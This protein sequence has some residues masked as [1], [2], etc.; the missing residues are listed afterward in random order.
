LLGGWQLS[1]I[2]TARQGNGW[3]SVAANCTL[4]SAGSCYADLN[5]NFTGPIRINGSPSD[6]NLRATNAPSFLAT[7]VF[8]NP[9]AYA[10]GN[11]PRSYV[12]KLHNVNSF[13]QNASLKREFRLRERMKLAL[14]IDASN[15][16]NMVIFG[17]P[18]NAFNSTAYG[19]VTSANSPRVVQ[20]NGRLTF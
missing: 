17:N 16:Y 12:Y 19:K 14:Q 8:L 10:Y 9:A 18:S 20:F 15:V 2:T 11:S 1:G 7:G 3:G 5:A 13:N 6:A 4:P